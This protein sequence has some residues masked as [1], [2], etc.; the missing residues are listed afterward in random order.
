LNLTAN[1]LGEG[2]FKA[3]LLVGGFGTRLRP[4]L[5]FSPKPLAS[6]GD[7]SF[8]ELLIAQLRS[9]GIRNLVMCT[10]HLGEQIKE[11]FGDGRSWGVAIEYSK[12]LS[13]L[14]TA[15]AIKLAKKYLQA[16]PEFVV[17]NGDSFLEV[18]LCHLI[19][20]HRQHAGLATMAVVQVKN[21]A[22]YGTVDIDVEGRVISFSEKAGLDVPGCV[23][24]GVYVFDR[25]I[26]EYIPEGPAS[27]E[28]EIFPRILNHGVYALVAEGMFIDIGTPEDYARAQILH[29]KLY[30]IASPGQENSSVESR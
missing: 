25:S 15:G 11:K 2:D 20:L 29:D 1:Q 19:R 30:K 8:L 27:L 10:G 4:I 5:P 14:G 28:K 9:H 21:V 7:R 6:V 18:D 22:R 17:M 24:G 26:L 23:N 12:E 13:P 3:V 16:A